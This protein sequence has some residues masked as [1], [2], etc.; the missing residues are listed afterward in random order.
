MTSLDRRSFLGLMSAAAVTSSG[1]LWAQPGTR[2]IDRLGVQLYTVRTEME[3][4]FD[5]TL[6][7]VA[8][9]GYKEVEFAG[10]FNQTPPSVKA[11]LARHGLTAPSAHIDFASLGPAKLPQVLEASRAIGHD[12][13]VLPWVDD[14]LRRKPD[15][16][17]KVAATLNG[18]G[19]ASRKAG[20]QLAYHNHH[21]EFVPIGGKLPFDILLA[22]CDPN[23]V[24]FELDLCWI[25]VAGHDPLTY[26]RKYPGRFPMVHVKDV[27]KV[28]ARAAGDTSMIPFDLV[29]PEITEV[30]S[31]MIDWKSIFAGVPAGGIEHYFVEHDQPGLPFDS[32]MTSAKYLQALRF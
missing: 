3:E 16:W 5:D 6:A 31:G 14:E 10:Y 12:Y 26:F 4:R 18:A 25:V 28:P 8:A 32:I 20:I 29:F 7:R 23:L 1:T 19:E 11:A 17:Q 27:R 24:R 9:A 2:K 30:G 21:F 15:V 13:I 22:Q